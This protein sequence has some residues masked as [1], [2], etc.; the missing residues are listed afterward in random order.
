MYEKWQVLLS[1]EMGRTDPRYAVNELLERF[2]VQAIRRADTARD[3]VATYQS[4]AI[5]VSY[6]WAET[7]HSMKHTICESGFISARA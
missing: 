1:E 7:A 4:L 2:L 5:S 6:L 3:A